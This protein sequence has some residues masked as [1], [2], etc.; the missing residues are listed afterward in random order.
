MCRICHTVPFVCL[1]LIVLT[2]GTIRAQTARPTVNASGRTRAPDNKF[3][4]KLIAK[5]D[6]DAPGGRR[7]STR[8]GDVRPVGWGFS[9]VPSIRGELGTPTLRSPLF[10][11]GSM[12]AQKRGGKHVGGK[13]SKGTGQH[14]KHFVPVPPSADRHVSKLLRHS[15]RIDPNSV[16]VVP[17]FGM[18]TQMTT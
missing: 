2:A 9:T 3:A 6:A 16:Q 15:N 8:R 1:T 11:R 10:A 13:N 5:A 4:P 12:G 17:M 7:L 14:S 18:R